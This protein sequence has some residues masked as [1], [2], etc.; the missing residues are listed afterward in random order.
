MNEETVIQILQLLI[1]AAMYFF[2]L[3]LKLLE[4]A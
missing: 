3:I 4:Q 1:K 2:K